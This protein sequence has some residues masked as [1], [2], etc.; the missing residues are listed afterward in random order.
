MSVEQKDALFDRLF[1]VGRE[2]GYL[3]F[4]EL[5]ELIPPEMVSPEE[6]DEMVARLISRRVLV[7][8]RPEQ[9]KLYRWLVQ[10]PETEIPRKEKSAEKEEEEALYRDPVQI[11]L[12]EMGE[13]SLMKREEEIATARAIEEGEKAMLMGLMAVTTTAEIFEKW[14]GQLKSGELASKH[15]LAESEDEEED[16]PTEKLVAATLEKIS[17]RIRKGAGEKEPNQKELLKLAELVNDLKLLPARRMELVREVY[18]LAWT[19]AEGLPSP[20]EEE[21]MSES[22]RKRIRK[23][24]RRR[25][26]RREEK[27]GMAA[28]RVMWA[29]TMVEEGNQQAVA[30]RKEMVKANLRLVVSIA[31]RYKRQGMHLLDLIQEGNLGLMKAVEKYE[32]RRGYKFGTYAT[33]WIRQS[34]N[35]A[36][37]DQGRTIRIP[38][39]M[40]EILGKIYRFSRKLL[41]QLGREP[42][43]EEIA[44]SSNIS[45][46][47]VVGLLRMAPEPISLESPV[48]RE[49]DNVLADFLPDESFS[50]PSDIAINSSLNDQTRKI[51]ATL[52]PREETV[53]KMRYGIGQK[54]VYTLEE[55][56]KVFKVSRERV[57]QIETRAIN[58]LRQ[59]SRAIKLKGFVEAE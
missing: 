12:K 48:G 7:V 21:K 34:I 33:W 38:V 20:E 11:Y 15:I 18:H 56:G 23:N 55:V 3:T 41:Q 30:A 53:L 19:M 57:R 14:A 49:E 43:P 4:S 27:L 54:N 44:Q 5:N 28:G 26:R 31:K 29:A 47:K 50:S 35:R 42:T 24:A 36:I 17:R 10:A 22:E 37:A 39:H 16:Y 6:L 52:S 2:K 40:S 45:V 1:N 32:Y 59:P 51:L 25:L 8:E 58:K 13:R 46:Q 9:V